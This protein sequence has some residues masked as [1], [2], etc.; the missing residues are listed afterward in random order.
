[1]AR[2]RGRAR[3]SRRTPGRGRRRILGI[4]VLIALLAPWIAPYGEHER[5]GDVF[6]HPSSSHWLGLDDGGFDMLS[7]MM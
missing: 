6:A 4:V 1:M 7:L 5:V 3:D 2:Q